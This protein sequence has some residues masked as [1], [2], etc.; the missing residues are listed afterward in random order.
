M[1]NWLY[2]YE[3]PYWT[4]M[5]IA[6]NDM[7]AGVAPI[8][9]TG[10]IGVNLAFFDFHIIPTLYLKEDVKISNG[11]GTKQNPFTLSL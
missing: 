5:P 8:N 4:M 6:R 3:T 11:I 10:N 9:S 1:S 7:L 2:K